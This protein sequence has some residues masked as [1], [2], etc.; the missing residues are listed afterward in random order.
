MKKIAWKTSSAL[1]VRHAEQRGRDGAPEHRY[2]VQGPVFFA[3]ADAFVE[4]FDPRQAEGQAVVIDVQGA[5]F[6]DVTALAAL[7]K[8]RARFEHHGCSVQ[9]HGLWDR[10]LLADGIEDVAG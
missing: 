9:V 1:Q 5:R 3:S 10:P 8:V 7:D 2:I 6:W 4:A